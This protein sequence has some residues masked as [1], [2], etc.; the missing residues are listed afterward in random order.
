MIKILVAALLAQ[1]LTGGA[2]CKVYESKNLTTDVLE[3][4]AQTHAVIVEKCVGVVVDDDGNGMILNA[5]DSQD[6]ISYKKSMPKQG[7]K[8]VTFNVFDP[9]NNAVDDIMLRIDLPLAAEK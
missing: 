9:T 2:S 3:H 6:Y 4:R 1:S 7:T 5:M 8:I